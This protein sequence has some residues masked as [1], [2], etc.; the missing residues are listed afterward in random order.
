M[1]DGNI[2]ELKTSKGEHG[3]ERK[4]LISRNTRGEK[5]IKITAGHLV[6]A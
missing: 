5:Q 1:R 3:R 2:H 6:C 4:L